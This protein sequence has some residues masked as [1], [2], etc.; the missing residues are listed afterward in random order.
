MRP[1]SEVI[2]RDEVLADL[3]AHVEHARRGEGRVVVVRGEAGIGKTTVVRA[4]AD[5]VPA[6]V[7][8][9]CGW[10]DDLQVAR[11]LGPIWDMVA[12]LPELRE[13]LAAGAPAAVRESIL[14]VLCARVHPVL[15]VVEDIHWADDATRDLLLLLGRRIQRVPLTVILTMRD[16]PPGDPVGA[17]I[18]DLPADGV[19]HVELERWSAEI[20]AE[21]APSPEV[22]D[23]I[24]EDTGG[25]PY[26]VVALLR[27]TSDSGVPSSVRDLVAGFVSRL[28][29]T[30]LELVQL[31]SVVPSRV[32]AGLIAAVDP[33]L[34]EAVAG[35]VHGGLL[36]ESGGYVSFRHE[37]TR[38]TVEEGLSTAR[39]RRLHSAVLAA[40]ERLGVDVARL[41]HHAEGAGDV[42]AMLRVLPTAARAAAE[43]HSHRQAIAHL[44]GLG[45][46]MERLPVEEQVELNCMWAVEAEAT[47]ADGLPQALRAVRL[48]RGGSDPRAHSWAL[49][50]ASRA[51]W[52]Q[53]DWP[54]A[55]ELADEAAGVLED[56]PGEEFA[57]AEAYRARYAA[58]E[59]DL[60]RAVALARRA[61]EL[62]PRPCTA[63][64]LAT[65][66]LG[67]VDNF[68]NYPT[69]S[70]RLLDAAEMAESLALPWW[71]QRARSN[72][73]D[74]AMDAMDFPLAR[75]LLAA[76]THRA[77]TDPVS[78][79]TEPW[80]AVK[81]AFLDGLTGHHHAAI[82]ALGRLID[83]G[84]LP[85]TLQWQAGAYRA[86]MLERAGAPEAREALEGCRAWT[87]DQGPRESQLWM[88]WVGAEFRW[89]HDGEPARGT[90]PAPEPEVTESREL[91]A[92]YGGVATWTAGH[93]ALRLWLRGD[94]DAMP[95][96]AP[97][98]LRWVTDGRWRQAAD[99]F[100]D[101]E[102]PFE[103]AL[104][105]TRGDVDARIEA[106]RL[107]Y[108]MEAKPLAAR[109][110]AGL[111][112]DGVTTLPRGPR[113]ATRHSVLGLTPRQEEVLALVRE[114]LSNADIAGRLVISV[115]TAENHVAA[116][117]TAL[118]VSSREEAARLAEPPP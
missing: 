6:D 23:R 87:R 68:R 78:G 99:W 10:C 54:R 109:V 115:R 28:R 61:L 106:L 73:V 13:A 1:L 15:L 91:L 53:A 58:L 71:A 46:M 36:R 31:V 77:R 80:C 65:N 95:D 101:R 51:A 60:D 39:R 55:V 93:L 84:A 52:G 35:G 26:L 8:V 40:G 83:G 67:L 89:L 22:A 45:S 86:H 85:P 113:P 97:A 72:H 118:G 47:D 76:E 56:T 5:S 34:G 32:E 79:A 29:G 63:R 7:R 64:V 3:R 9:L 25:N 92:R 110:R 42:E 50:L 66:V 27:G 43:R 88:A 12:D 100:G 102:A 62:A 44:S 103:Q 19:R 94:I 104:A 38:R 57:L 69:G 20:V 74:T 11:P 111:V 18:G 81:T 21:L 70:P 4:L 98:P 48:S 16:V 112:A 116:V 37:L 14:E 75:S 41:A 17:L 107:A 33:V 90:D 59:L 24:L 96:S 108:G 82:A 114:G 30:D 49:I 2:G 117:L 105:L